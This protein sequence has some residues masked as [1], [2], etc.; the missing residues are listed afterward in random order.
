MNKPQIDI[1]PYTKQF[2]KGNGINVA[3]LIIVALGEVIISL[4][5]S[6]LLLALTDLISGSDVGF[7]L[8]QLLMIGVGTILFAAVGSMLACYARPRY[9]TRG[10]S[11]YKARVFEEITKKNIA[12]F[13]GE[14][15]STYVSAL[16]ND[17]KTIEQGFL[18]NTFTIITNVLTFVGALTMMI[19][20]SP[21]LTLIAI[22][23]ALFPLLAALLTGQNMANKEKQVSSANELYTATMKDVLGGFPV[24]KSFKAEAQVLR[25]FKERVQALSTAERG[26]HK[27]RAIVE[28]FGLIATLIAQIGVFV[29]GAYL[30]LS[31]KG[32]TAG[33]TILFVQ[34]MNYVLSPIGTLPTCF[35]ERSSAKALVEKVATALNKNVREETQGEHCPL[36]KGITVENLCFGYEQDK[37]VLHNVNCRFD[38]GKKYAVVGASGSGK[39]TLLNLLLA[40]YTS[41][42][43]NIYFDETE[44][45]EIST[46]SLYETESIIQQNVFIFNATIRDNITMFSSFP[47]E[48]IERAIALS[49]LS[50][51]IQAKGADYLCGENGNG[52][53][54][55]EK[56]RVAIARSL[57]KKS[58][59]L[60][61]DEATAALDSET[62][63]QVFDAILDLDQVTSIVVTHAL[64]ALQ[65]KKY[66]EILTMKNGCIVEKGTFEK[67]MEEKGYFY[68]LFTV[69]Q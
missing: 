14:N 67:L 30:A 44:L 68:S 22:A 6:W 4:I 32:V 43:G 62:A 61:V 55:G 3:L 5:C 42:Q 52:L 53:S 37:Q 50:S 20:Y 58:Q 57:L 21:L 51:V 31:G 64:D 2:Y 23:L 35:A 40:S 60:L 19:Y 25:I 18:G 47:E 65:L 49:G 24:I 39:S 1:R 38:L 7:T 29:V 26:K 8:F 66:D 34:L 41:Y 11:Q 12:A 17:I 48:E 9:F 45:K 46:A 10:I 15:S 56:Q 27:M 13:S 28:F 69:S 54:G 33:T 63:K 16:T 36:Q 59:V